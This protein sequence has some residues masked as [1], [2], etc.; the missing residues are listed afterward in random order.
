IAGTGY[1]IAKA[2][3]LPTVAC[4]YTEVEFQV[5]LLQRDLEWAGHV[6]PAARKNITETWHMKLEALAEKT[7]DAGERTLLEKAREQLQS[8]FKL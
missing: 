4:R 2:E 7:Y 8:T 5:A 3:R 6:D 1:P